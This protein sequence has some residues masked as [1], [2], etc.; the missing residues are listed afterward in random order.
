MAI[1]AQI[2]NGIV[3]NLIEVDPGNV[4]EW[5]ADWPDGENAFLGWLYV[6]GVFTAPPPPPPRDIPNYEAVNMIVQM[7]DGAAVEIT[8][9]VPEVERLSWTAKEQAA[10]A[11]REGRGADYMLETEA[12]LT[13]ETLDD[14][15][16]KIIRNADLYRAAVAAMTGIRRAALAQIEAGGSTAEIVDRVRTELAAL[17][18]PQ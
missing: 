13:G 14:L 11:Y 6:D 17:I 16:A 18:K 3:V 12:A 9:E 2:E 5:C 4:P 10:R 7:I 8:G 1:K 15:T